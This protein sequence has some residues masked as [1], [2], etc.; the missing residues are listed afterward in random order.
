MRMAASRGLASF[1][2]L[3]LMLIFFFEILIFISPVRSGAVPSPVHESLGRRGFKGYKRVWDC[4]KCNEKQNIGITVA[5]TD[6]LDNLQF[7]KVNSRDLSSSWVWENPSCS[8]VA[9]LEVVREP[10]DDYPSTIKE[11]QPRPR[12]IDADKLEREYLRQRQKEK[13]AVQLVQLNKDDELQMQNAAIERSRQFKNPIREMRDK[14]KDSKSPKAASIL[15]IIKDQ[16]VMAKV[17]ASIALSKNNTGLADSLMK[18]VKESRRAIGGA[19]SGAELHSRV[20]ECAKAMANVLLLAKHKL[21]DCSAV[22]KKL[23]AMVQSTEE[24]MNAL[25]KQG[26]FLIQDAVKTIPNPLHYIPLQLTADY[27]LRHHSIK[28]AVNKKKLVDRSLY[29]YAIFS[30]NVIATSVVV[31]STVSNAKEP[32]NHVFHIVTDRWNFGAMKMWFLAHSL[33]PATIHIKKID[34]FK[35]LNSSYCSILR[36]GESLSLRQFYFSANHPASVSSADENLKFK[37]PKFLSMLNHLRF[38]LPEL[39]PKLDKILFLDD[40][41]VVQTD[42]TPLWSV[43]MKGMVNGAVETCRGTFHRYQSYLNFSHPIIQ[44]N[45]DSQACGWAFGMNIFDLKEWRLRNL[46]QTYHYWQDLNEER[47]LWKL[48]TMPPGLMT[49]Y[50]LTYPLDERWHLLKLGYDG[51]IKQVMIERAA[52]IHFNGIYKPWSALGFS[53]YVPYWSKYLHHQSPYFQPLALF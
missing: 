48:G 21:Y 26:F 38:Y 7:Y 17:Y 12:R 15:K 46:T 8:N 5:Y 43:D 11:P 35:W 32:E 36:Q 44:Q 45:F 31:N 24:S 33:S 14:W 20:L 2:L 39:Y 50:R 10:K 37:N 19:D 16:I 22:T 41:V 23:R 18:H 34:D 40:D 6:A 53:R 1:G 28:K 52:V 4:G 42:L 3:L 13:R 27:Y 49:F 47:Q 30:D 51:T 9:Q 29:H 25:I